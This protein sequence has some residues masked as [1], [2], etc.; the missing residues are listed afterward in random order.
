MSKIIRS[1]Y[2]INIASCFHQT[3]S[4]YAQVEV[5]QLSC[6]RAHCSLLVNDTFLIKLLIQTSV[7][8]YPIEDALVPQQA[9]VPLGHPMTFIWEVQEATR[10]TEALQ[11]VERLQA[12]RDEHTVVEIVVDNEFRSAEIG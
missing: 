6:S 9:V 11:Y 7:V 12:L 3:S 4:H 1:G 10:D 5:A 2:I 8:P